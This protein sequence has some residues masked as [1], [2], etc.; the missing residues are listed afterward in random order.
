MNDRSRV[1]ALRQRTRIAR[2][3]LLVDDHSVMTRKA[4]RAAEHKAAECKIA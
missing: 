1:R 3:S 4:E 2:G